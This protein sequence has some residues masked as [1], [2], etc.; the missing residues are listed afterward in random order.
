MDCLRCPFLGDSELILGC[1]AL[2]GGL[3]Q[4]E[5]DE[6]SD[7]GSSV[8]LRALDVCFEGDGGFDMYSSLLRF[9]PRFSPH[10]SFI[11]LVPAHSRHGFARSFAEKRINR[12]RSPVRSMVSTS[13]EDGVSIFR[14]DRSGVSLG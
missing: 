8:E 7:K 13:L 10:C 9:F 14:S 6:C 3:T 4:L 2:F 1:L 11:A 5:F 12:S